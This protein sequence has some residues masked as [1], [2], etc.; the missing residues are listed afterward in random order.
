MGKAQKE[1]E[2]RAQGLAGE[3]GKSE[4][5]TEVF[6]VSVANTEKRNVPLWLSAQLLWV[7]LRALGT[8]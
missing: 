8:L 7:Q 5:P 6:A 1:D 4:D 2:K 3:K